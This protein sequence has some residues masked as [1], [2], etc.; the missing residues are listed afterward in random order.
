[1]RTTACYLTH[2]KDLRYEATREG[3]RQRT[4]A[5]VGAVPLIQSNARI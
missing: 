3:V 1:M 4:L 5:Q 2:G